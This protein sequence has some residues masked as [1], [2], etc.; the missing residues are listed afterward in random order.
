[1]PLLDGKCEAA[2]YLP[3]MTVYDLYSDLTGA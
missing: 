3:G 1:M 2:K